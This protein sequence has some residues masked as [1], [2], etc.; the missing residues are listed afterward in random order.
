MVEMNKMRR[1]WTCTFPLV[2]EVIGRRIKF[3]LAKKTI[4]ARVWRDW[5]DVYIE[6]T[7]GM[8]MMIVYWYSFSNHY[9]RECTPST[10]VNEGGHGRGHDGI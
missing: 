2:C 4:S 5:A 8:M 7:K 6:W 9:T 1:S 10:E 3:I